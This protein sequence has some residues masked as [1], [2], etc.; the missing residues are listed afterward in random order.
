M[1]DPTDIVKDVS[2]P[3]TSSLSDAWQWLLGDRIAAWRLENA[4]KI[5]VKVNTK[6]AA[7]GLKTVPARIPERYAMAWFE[8][9]TKQDETE[10]QDLF[11][12]LLANAAAGD[13]DAADRR[14]LE[15]VARFVPLDAK[16]MDIFYN[17]ELA[18]RHMSQAGEL[19]EVSVDEWSLY[20]SLKDEFGAR[21]W[22]SVE[23]LIA[24]GVLEKRNHISTE[25]VTRLLSN[26]QTDTSS[27]LVYPSYGSGT[28]L[29]V[30]A[31][32]VSTLTGL[33]LMRALSD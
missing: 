19:V 23:H 25:S 20:K 21:G 18:K 33:S 13:E 29:E 22:Q 15:I 16:V 30:M 12:R 14:H 10:I 5:Q 7:L 32:I 26:L 31:E 17:G 6:L 2:Q 11:A 27:G 28:E 24:L 1:I 8:E 3:L 4:A 9:A